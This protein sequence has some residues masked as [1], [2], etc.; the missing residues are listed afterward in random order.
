MTRRRK[1]IR[2]SVQR[3]NDLESLRDTDES[4]DDDPVEGSKY[5]LENEGFGANESNRNKKRSK[6]STTTDPKRPK[7][8][9][10]SERQNPRMGGDKKSQG[11]NF[12]SRWENMFERLTKYKEKIGNT[13]VPRSY[14]QDKQL[15]T[16][17]SDK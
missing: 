4:G 11:V 5:E 2:K 1:I 8:R 9:K 6:E 7:K 13:L 14:K 15:G 12:N 10:K 17:V 3:G 16:W